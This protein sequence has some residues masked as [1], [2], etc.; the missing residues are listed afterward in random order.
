MLRIGLTGPIFLAF[1]FALAT[2]ANADLI[3]RLDASFSWTSDTSTGL[4]WLDFAVS[5]DTTA[6]ANHVSTLGRS[7]VAVQ[8]ELGAGG[9]YEGWRYATREETE[10]FVRNVWGTNIA[11][12]GS[13]SPQYAGLTAK[14][15]AFTGY[16]TLSASYEEVSG[17][18]YT[19]DISPG[20]FLPVVGTYHLLA[21][22][23]D[24]FFSSAYT[25]DPSSGYAGQGHWLVRSSQVPEPTTLALLCLGLAGLGF[26]R[27][28]H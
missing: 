8:S 1:T 20:A 3:K 26:S 25:L 2:N 16:T 6:P 24:G 17:F 18:V 14:V 28:K 11:V 13:P 12:S 22:V 21:M 19:A 5:G 23:G 4:E 7:Y 9:D 10:R 27:R 15:A